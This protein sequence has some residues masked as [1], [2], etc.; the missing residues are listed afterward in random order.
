MATVSATSPP[1]TE[2]SDGFKGYRCILAFG[3]N[4]SIIIKF[5]LDY[6]THY[7]ECSFIFSSLQ[8]ISPCERAA[9]L[10][11]QASIAKISKIDDRM[12]ESFE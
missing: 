4:T 6:S 12:A 2:G 8:Q 5:G 1:I 9:C 3:S 10:L 7:D 11:D